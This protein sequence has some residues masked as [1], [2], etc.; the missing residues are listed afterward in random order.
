MSTNNDSPAFKVIGISIGE[1]VHI[2]MKHEAQLQGMSLSEIIR[3]I[4]KVW[5]QAILD[6]DQSKE[7]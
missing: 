4:F 2:Q 7:D 6:F 3:S 1:A 5:L